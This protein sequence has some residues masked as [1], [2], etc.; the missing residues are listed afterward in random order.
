MSASVETVSIELNG[1]RLSIEVGRMAKQADGAAFV[2]FGES[3]VLATAVSAE[4]PRAEGDFFPLTCDYIERTY[5]AGKIPGG[6]FK[7]EGRPTEK[8]VLTSRLIDRPHRPLFPKGYLNDTQII[9]TAVSHDQ[10]NDPDVLAMVAASTAVHVSDIPFGG[11]IAAVRVGRVN[12][13]LIANPTNDQREQSDLEVVLAGGREAIVMVE[14]GARE[15]A[16][17]VMIEALLFG[18]AALQPLLD[19]QEELRRRVGKP[20]RTFTPP[21][22]PEGLA[23]RVR[24]L[25]EGR[26]REAIRV[27][28]KHERRDLSKKAVEETVAALLPEFPEHE[29]TI[30]K[31][32]EAL[33]KEIVR[34]RVAVERVRLDGRGP[35]DIRPISIEVG[36]LPRAHGSALFT[37][38]ETQALV[39]TTL[40]TGEDMQRIDALEGDYFKRFMLHYNFPPFSTGEVKFLR[41]PGR[42]EI[43]HG[44]LAERAIRAVLPSE[45]EFGYAIRVVSDILESNGSSSMATVCGASLSLM[46]AGVKVKAPVAGIAMGLIKEGD[47]VAIISDILGDEDHLGDMD[48]KVAGTEQG[49]TALQMD[50]KIA[51]VTR[52]ILEAALRQARDG[53]LFILQKMKEAIAAPRAE[54]SAHAP[55]ITTIQIR[56]EK[57]REL[58]GPGGKV[59]K[60]IIEQTGVKIDVEDSG[61][62]NI[63]S[64]DGKAAQRAID[65]IRGIVQE[66]E[67]GRLYMGK[68]KKIMDFGAFVE[69]FPGTDGLVHISQLAEKRVNKVEDV[70]KEGDE[71]LVKVLD[72]D[73]NSGKIRL[74]RKEALG[75]S[76]P[77]ATSAAKVG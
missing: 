52:A 22:V 6:F 73:P 35:A 65:I 74:S 39:A 17:Q 20:K 32:G 59:I 26:L 30:K 34:K 61:K 47:Q 4:E 10:E 55:R 45:A 11:P 37:R 2:R 63:A 71:V 12:G 38:G 67:I 31:A 70:L 43:G 64:T 5:A 25:C 21:P 58:I 41:A 77:G 16:E 60:G 14:A 15:V 75:Q 9:A 56:P 33:E 68:V 23:D 54:L 27:A 51:G 50:I 57:I 1:Q 66:A 8:E 40:G 3:A 48:F 36:L 19:L 69:I 72:V 42:R 28:G 46:D 13:Q 7:R 62:V 49:V 44:A 76:L 53:R 29:K 18:H 24:A